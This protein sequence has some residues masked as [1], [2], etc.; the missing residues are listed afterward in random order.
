MRQSVVKSRL[1]LD[2][3]LAPC[4]ERYQAELA[5]LKGQ[6]L[7][8]LK[9]SSTFYKSTLLATVQRF[10]EDEHWEEQ[11]SL[12]HAHDAMCATLLMHPSLDDFWRQQVLRFQLLSSGDKRHPFEIIAGHC[13]YIKSTENRGRMS[14]EWL[15]L[16][17]G[18]FYDLRCCRMKLQLF[19]YILKHYPADDNS[20]IGDMRICQNIL[21]IAQELH[22][23]RSD[24][25]TQYYRA[26]ISAYA[27]TYADRAQRILAQLPAPNSGDKAA[28]GA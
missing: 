18:S 8:C 5:E 10:L 17:T 15:D 13:C 6:L 12:L 21:L 1:G 7:D 24:E 25:L 27:S 11:L 16:G 3:P 28:P 20:I 23:S 22:G 19:F 4:F 2:K 14:L 26:Q 9:V